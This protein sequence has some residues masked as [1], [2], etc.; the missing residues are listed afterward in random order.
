[1]ATLEIL[2]PCEE[3]TVNGSCLESNGGLLEG[4]VR[5]TLTKPTK[6]NSIT[7][8]F[9]GLLDMFIESEGWVNNTIAQ[10]SWNLFEAKDKPRILTPGCYRYPFTMQLPGN[11]PESVACQN[12]IISYGFVATVER[13][14]FSFNLVKK[15]GISIK[16]NLVSGKM[17]LVDPVLS[18][19]AARGKLEYFFNLPSGCFLPGQDIPINFQMVPDAS[20]SLDS[21]NISLIEV[22][23]F[24]LPSK[25][26]EKQCVTEISSTSI[27][28][29][30]CKLGELSSSVALPTNMRNLNSDC[31]TTPINIIHQIQCHV[32]LVDRITQRREQINIQ[33]PVII[34]S[35][36][37][38]DPF[39]SLPIYV[40][41]PPYTMGLP[42]YYEASLAA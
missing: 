1:M 31:Q 40:Q 33:L 19:G 36:T 5:L 25:G 34:I 32:V 24:S 23:K 2:L 12:A 14:L 39:E 8:R 30:V 11:T 20:L 38:K 10:N 21:I 22:R 16:R 28:N 4:Y 17:E 3:V 29:P 27:N 42:P 13:S 6:V 37:L 35:D 7:L 15:K 26:F 9:L 18:A 41:P